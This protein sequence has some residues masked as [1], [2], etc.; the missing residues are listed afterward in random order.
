VPADSPPPAVPVH[1]PI[2]HYRLGERAPEELRQQL[3][4]TVALNAILSVACSDDDGASTPPPLTLRIIIEKTGE[5]AFGVLTAFL[6][7]PFLTPIPLPGMS[8]LF[9]LALAILGIEIAVRRDRPWLPSRMLNWRLPPK[10]G[11]KLIYFV[12]KLFRPLERIIRPRLLFMQNPVAMAFVGVALALDGLL[13]ALPLP[14]VVPLS[15]ALPAWLGLITI[16]G[17]TEEDGVCLL[18][19]SGLTLG[20]VVGGIVSIVLFWDK[21]WAWLVAHFHKTEPAM[22]LLNYWCTSLDASANTMIPAIMR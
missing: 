20:S 19:G 14:P 10:L 8:I 6:C 11:P 22:L 17:I 7:L 12:A 15:N 3:R 21:F 4:L 9:G 13:L 2:E 16:L 1:K 5:R 18:I